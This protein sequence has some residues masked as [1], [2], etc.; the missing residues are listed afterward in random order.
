MHNIRMSKT[1][2]TTI[3]LL[4]SLT[5][6]VTAQGM[7]GVVEYIKT[8]DPEEFVSLEQEWHKVYKGLI[9]EEEISI[10]GTF[11]IMEILGCLK[12]VDRSKPGLG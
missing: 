9:K 8:D 7:I 4:L 12:A 6:G 11:S 5:F 10:K 3:F 2:L 1:L